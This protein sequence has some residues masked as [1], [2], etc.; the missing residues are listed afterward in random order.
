MS[1]EDVLRK[2]I[3]AF[4]SD[5][6]IIIIEII[7]RNKYITEYSIEREINLGIEKTRLVAN[8]LIKEKLI[9]YEDKF[10][11]N[12]RKKESPNER[13]EKKCFKLKIKRILRKILNLVVFDK[14]SHREA[15]VPKKAIKGPKTYGKTKGWSLWLN[16]G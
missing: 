1:P 15:L 5:L 4:F 11:K 14:S 3:R 6:H 13:S 10:F 12:L 8:N 9:S 2:V 16:K 7:L